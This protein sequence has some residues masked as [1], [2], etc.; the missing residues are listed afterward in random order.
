MRPTDHLSADNI[1]SRKDDRWW[2]LIIIIVNIWIIFLRN[3]D[4]SQTK[5][6]TIIRE[7]MQFRVLTLLLLLYQYKRLPV[8][9]WTRFKSLQ[10]LRKLNRTWEKR[11]S[12]LFLLLLTLSLYSLT[13]RQMTLFFYLFSFTIWVW[14]IIFIFF[15]ILL[16]YDDKGI[17]ISSGKR[18]ILYL[19]LLFDGFIF[20]FLLY[21]NLYFF[22]HP[23]YFFKVNSSPPFKWLSISLLGH[24]ER[25]LVGIIIV[26]DLKGRGDFLFNFVEWWREWVTR[27]ESERS[28][29]CGSLILW[30][31]GGICQLEMLLLVFF[32]LVSLECTAVF[33]VHKDFGEWG[34]FLGG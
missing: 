23:L 14:S 25:S 26:L 6:L 13:I 32:L 1:S 34:L 4:P 3:Y 29:E 15:S 19:K 7:R 8:V 16:L 20:L 2:D 17:I 10:W 31:L 30:L 22:L 27:S 28:L 21:L 12:F 24:K 18:Y 33:L 11:I 9:I 5:N